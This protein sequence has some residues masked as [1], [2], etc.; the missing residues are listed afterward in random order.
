MSVQAM[1]WVLDHSKSRL[2]SRLVLLAIANHSNESGQNAW[3]Q[4]STI[5]REAHV[6]ERQVQRSLV[7]LVA[8]GELFVWLQV[9]PR[10]SN[11]YQVLMKGDNLSP[12]RVTFAPV[13]GDIC[14]SAIR[15]NR[16]EPSKDL[17]PPTPLKKGGLCSTRMMRRIN[18]ALEKRKGA[19]VGIS[20][21]ER[22]KRIAQIC[23]DCGTTA[24]AYYAA[25]ENDVR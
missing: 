17:T 18:Q 3:P 20:N 23:S 11:V 21:A 13:K 2:A 12:S 16:P 8:L 6:G 19:W 14:S 9:G 7:E 24:A 10:R 4:V 15:K 25:S 5:A 1:S 22:E